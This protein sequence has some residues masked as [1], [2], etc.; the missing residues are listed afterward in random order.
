MIPL[1][2]FSKRELYSIHLAS[3]DILQEV[4]VI[5]PH[6]EVLKK[7][8]EMGAEVD[9]KKQRVCI[10]PYL[11]EE[12]IRKTPHRYSVYYRDMKTK[13]VLGE[14]QVYFGTVGFATKFFDA[15]SKVYR[16]FT[17]QD[18][19]NATK[20]ADA[21]ENVDL[22]MT[23]GSPTDVPKELV[24]RYMWMISFINTKKHVINEA[25]GK[26]GALDAIEMASTIVGGKEELRKKPILTVL[27]CITSP[28]SYY[29]ETLE[30]FVEACKFGIPTM[31]DSGPIVGATSPVTFAGTLALNVA[32]L[33]SSLVISRA[34]NE[35]APILISS[36]ARAIDM[37][38]G[39]AVLG[40]PEFAL[41]HA[42]LAQMSR[43]YGIPSGGGGI[44]TDSKTLDIQAGYEKALT[45]VVPAL[46]GLNLICGVGLIASEN[47]VSLE[48]FILDDEIISYVKRIIRG[49]E[50]NEETLAL[51]VIKKVG[52]L[53]NFIKEK[54]TLTHYKR[55]LWIPKLTDHSFPEVWL[56]AGAKDLWVKA[57][58]KVE[59]ILVE[60]E[61]EPLPKD[62]RETLEKI[63]KKR[64]KGE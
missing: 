11:S 17:Q 5:V 28:L 34:V 14:D 56:K 53:G 19:A 48:Q 1:E 63:I 59:K 20:L 2:L 26:E 6:E 27:T 61:V 3:L 64:V 47:A 31:V 7:L 8:D 35:K 57:S 32:E 38:E 24:D 52:P 36:W 55:E 58:E 45:A 37:R 29:R 43:Y 46:A 42:V 39:S 18:L 4:G 62:I 10:P 44:L 50:V 30:A 60:H 41:L 54:H 12:A 15:K 23:V 33:I 16:N 25:M 9:Y 22:Y 13:K 51:D 21:M 40:G 49:I